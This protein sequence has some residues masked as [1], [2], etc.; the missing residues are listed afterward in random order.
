M[1]LQM[2]AARKGW[3]LEHVEVRLSHRR[4]HAR[5]CEECEG[6]EGYL[7]LIEKQIVVAG[8]LTDEQVRRLAEIAEKC[9]VNKTL[10]A[11][12]QTRQTIRCAGPGAGSE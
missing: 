8:G 12:V 10:H 5:D 4:V 7:D 1:T 3:P 6:R 9:P 11:T 2:Y